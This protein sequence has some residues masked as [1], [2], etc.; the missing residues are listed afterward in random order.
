MIIGIAVLSVLLFIASV[1]LFVQR[2]GLVILEEKYW[3]ENRL[4]L[5]TKTRLESDLDAYKL[6]LKQSND[7][8]NLYIHSCK[9]RANERDEARTELERAQ[10]L[11]LE[12][13]NPAPPKEEAEEES[14]E[15]G[16]FVRMRR[17]RPATAETYRNVFDLTVDGQRILEDLT[18]Q[19]C[20]PSY[21]RGGA[22]AERESCYRAGQSSVV[23]RILAKINTANDPDYKEEQ[24]ND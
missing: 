3:D 15:Q 10:K 17:V 24:D 14:E 11:I 7:E 19:F 6:K 8:L 22:D 18:S 16:N 13:S 4:H 12:L 21:V 20:K 23:N 2:R 9:A 1:A 5:D